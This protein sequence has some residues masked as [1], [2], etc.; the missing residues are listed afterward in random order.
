MKKVNIYTIQ[1][2]YK[3][4]KSMIF[5]C[6]KFEVE[7]GIYSWIIPEGL[8]PRP[9]IMNVDAIESVWLLGFK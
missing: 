9:L 7:N 5:D 3:S 8:F 4:G 1:I 6:S 2:N